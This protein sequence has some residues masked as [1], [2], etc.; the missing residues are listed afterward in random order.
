MNCK[1]CGNAIGA[2]LKFCTHCGTPVEAAAAPPPAPSQPAAAPPA[3]SCSKCG[4]P[5][6]PGLRFCTA[7]G[8]RVEL[9][10]APN[11]RPDD[12]TAEVTVVAPP[13]AK[14]VAEAPAPKIAARSVD[15]PP[16]SVEIS[17][18]AKRI[19]EPPVKS[20]D[21]VPAA[22]TAARSVE[23]RP[24]TVEI[25]SEVKQ[26]KGGPRCAECGAAMM[27][28][29]RF[30]MACGARVGPSKAAAAAQPEKGPVGGAKPADILRPAGIAEPVQPA[31]PAAK[32]KASVESKP[33]PPTAAAHAV[34]PAQPTETVEPIG[35][36]AAD[37][38][39]AVAGPRL[40]EG[41][42]AKE[43]KPE[44]PAFASEGSREEA[45]AAAPEPQPP[46]KAPEPVPAAAAPI[47]GVCAKC[48]A[49]LSPGVR[50]CIGCGT[51]VPAQVEEVVAAADAVAAQ[52]PA[53]EETAA[54]DERPLEPSV[55]AEEPQ[56]AAA[57]AAPPASEAAPAAPASTAGVCAKCGTQ[58]TP[59]VRFCIGC[60]A[61][62]EWWH[63]GAVGAA[64]SAAASSVP[65]SSAA[66]APIQ[67]TGISAG[68]LVAIFLVLLVVLA[69]YA[70]W[71]V[72]SMR[73]SPLTDIAMTA[74]PSGSEDPTAEPPDSAATDSGLT[75]EDVGQ[76][77]GA[78]GSG[79]D[80]SPAQDEPAAEPSSASRAVS[81]APIGQSTPA[82]SS[83][84]TSA[85][86][87]SPATRKS[88]STPTA[89]RKALQTAQNTAPAP[90]TPVPFV[91]DP[92]PSST[93]QTVPAPST[94]GTASP[95]P[96]A[97]ITQP[98]PVPLQPAEPAAPSEGIIY[99]TGK[100]QRSK[101]F[102][103]STKG[104]D[105]GLADGK[106]LPGTPV[107]IRV[108]SPAVKVVEAPG[109]RNNW[110]RIILECTRN[111][112]QPVTINVQ[113]FAAR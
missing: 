23:A 32:A 51:A 102:I 53:P 31:G 86:L 37:P 101:R 9:A 29:A 83:S 26:V 42:G 44:E 7:C 100:L 96:A 91:D 12:N 103:I 48:G 56:E 107:E 105:Y 80:T 89:A 69:G 75:P 10:P 30:C 27:P 45:A 93:G 55:S 6:K 68:V 20:V 108:L 106:L 94:G 28:T 95:P 87:P 52:A 1:K 16:K 4:A 98:A 50:F 112:N 17:S 79:F 25:P 104:T 22:K 76:P 110:Q 85:G 15:A 57:T 58:V 33:T 41:A 61:P 47:A 67:R 73:F 60:G 5:L 38:V 81:S 39:P 65:P 62:V 113:W 109:P 2:G 97:A 19:E 71:L 66:P 78:A 84:S 74:I 46:A 14:G 35:P 92:A 63:T 99:W 43:V 40:T 88:A 21:A 24:Q 111:T 70:F 8:A 82:P 34:E 49:Q 13:P 64:A 90:R 72:R 77:T 59:G 11:A 54:A 18:G 3:P 36:V